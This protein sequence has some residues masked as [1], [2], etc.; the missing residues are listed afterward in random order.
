MKC[1]VIQDFSRLGPPLYVELSINQLIVYTNN[2]SLICSKNMA[3]T[4]KKRLWFLYLINLLL[5][6]YKSE[7]LFQTTSDIPSMLK[8]KSL[9]V[10]TS[11]AVW[12]PKSP[13]SSTTSSDTW[14]DSWSRVAP[15]RK[16]TSDSF[17]AG[18]GERGAT[19]LIRVSISTTLHSMNKT[20]RKSQFLWERGANIGRTSVTTAWTACFII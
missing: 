2:W 3:W 17:L 11:K 7:N 20:E 12:S 9:A 10:W 1:S 6:S 15:D 14:D 19:A 5:N 4:V 8:M 13:C 18:A 16:S